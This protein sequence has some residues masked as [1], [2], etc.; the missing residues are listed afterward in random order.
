MT[1]QAQRS[2]G[3]RRAAAEYRELVRVQGSLPADRQWI[4]GATIRAAKARAYVEA[5]AAEAIR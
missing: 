1:K 5:E 4:M 3:F 2:K